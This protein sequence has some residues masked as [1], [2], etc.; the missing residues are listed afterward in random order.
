MTSA[1]WDD[2]IS[3]I[4]GTDDPRATTLKKKILATPESAHYLVYDNYDWESSATRELPEDD[5]DL[6][7]AS[8]S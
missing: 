4:Y 6:G 5:F 3:T 7:Q 1:A 2:Y 8:G